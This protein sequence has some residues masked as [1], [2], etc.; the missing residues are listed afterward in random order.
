MN[1]NNGSVDYQK[2]SFIHRPIPN[3]KAKY[4]IICFPYA[5]GGLGTFLTWNNILHTDLELVII[6]MPGRGSRFLEEPLQCMSKLTSL[7]FDSIDSLFDRPVIFFG[8][9]LGTSVAYEVIR[10]LHQKG[11]VLPLLFIASSRKAPMLT[12]TEDPIHSLDDANFKLKLRE[13]GGTPA[14]VL[15]NHELMD[16][17]IP[18]LRADFKIAETYQ[19]Q[20][21]SVIPCNIAVFRG[22]EDSVSIEECQPWFSLFERNEG[23]HH[24]EGNHFFV[25]HEYW[26]ITQKINALIGVAII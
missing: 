15:D 10:L 4:R 23:L 20:E 24:F 13:L 22:N 5:G 7:L 12:P 18:C 2:N 8:H 25:D 3:S 9:S 6:Q 1:L 21:K 17:L 26:E 11:R 14:E 19:N 16:M